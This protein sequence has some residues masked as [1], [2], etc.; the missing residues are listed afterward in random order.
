[1]QRVCYLI[2][3]AFCWA[4][5]M[6]AVMLVPQDQKVNAFMGESVTFR[7]SMKGGSFRNYY[8]FWYRK[9]L[10]STLTFVYREGGMYGPG[11]WDNFQGETDYSNNQAVLK[12]LK[13]SERDEG[14]YYCATTTLL[15]V[16]FRTA[17]KPWNLRNW[18]LRRLTF[19]PFLQA[20][21]LRACLCVPMVLRWATQLVKYG[22]AWGRR[23]KRQSQSQKLQ[24]LQHTLFF[25]FFFFGLFCL[26]RA[27]PT[28]HGGSQARS[29]IG[30]VARSLTQ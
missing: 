28:A 3:L 16:H 30:G 23:E 19:L 22:P 27:A 4:G 2:H 8:N 7:C 5:V 9:T 26:F 13:A 1:M 21:S 17:Q 24:H 6:S 11:F 14:S 10:G 15:W 12:I 29:L 20:P 25:F 18:G